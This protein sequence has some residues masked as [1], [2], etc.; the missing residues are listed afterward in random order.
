M[1]NLRAPGINNWDL[2]IQ[3]WWALPQERLRVQFRAETYNTFNHANFYAPNQTFGDPSF[4][5]IT[6]AL[7]AR[8]IQMGL[9][10]YW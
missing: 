6:G 2:A 10:V 1:P 4:G 5:R 7:P 8:S 9:K 3:K